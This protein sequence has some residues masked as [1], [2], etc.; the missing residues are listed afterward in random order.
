MSVKSLLTRMD[1]S[2]SLAPDPGPIS[3]AREPG[4]PIAQQA[5]LSHLQSQQQQQQQQLSLTG[6]APVGALSTLLGVRPSPRDSVHM[7]TH[8]VPAALPLSEIQNNPSLI[9]L[10]VAL[11]ALQLLP[12][13]SEPYKLQ[14]QHIQVCGGPLQ[15]Q[16][17]PTILRAVLAGLNTSFYPAVPDC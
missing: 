5:Q 14:M 1:G 6:A 10:Q 2:S 12:E 16:A 3:S 13:G 4:F 15:L 7:L 11:H 17:L 8:T 9:S